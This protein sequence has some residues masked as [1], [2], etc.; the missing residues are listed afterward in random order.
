VWSRVRIVHDDAR[1]VLGLNLFG[2][3]WDDAI[4]RRW[5]EEKRELRWVV[6]H[7]PDASFDTELVPPLRIPVEARP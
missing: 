1:T 4:L 6:D 7:L 3:R 5:I 2:R